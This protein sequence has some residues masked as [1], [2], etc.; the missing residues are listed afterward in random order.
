PVQVLGPGRVGSRQVPPAVVEMA[1]EARPEARGL[2]DA[3]PGDHVPA[4]HRTRRRD[5]ADPVART[6]AGRR[7]H[8]G[9]IRGPYWG[10]RVNRLRTITISSSAARAADTLLRFPLLRIENATVSPAWVVTY[11]ERP[12]TLVSVP[13]FARTRT[14]GPREPK[15]L[16][17]VPTEPG[18]ARDSRK[19]PPRTGSRLRNS[20]HRTNARGVA[21]LKGE[22]PEPSTKERSSVSI[23]VAAS[24]E[25]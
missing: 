9:T 15:R 4:Q 19:I 20:S 3:E 17:S 6:K 16:W 25:V 14:P 13:V 5:D 22:R 2:E 23:P 12:L 8:R 21:R 18:A 24:I 1:A 11:P 10:S 7:D